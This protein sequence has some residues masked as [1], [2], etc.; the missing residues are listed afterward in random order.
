MDGWI[1]ICLLGLAKTA[2]THCLGW[3][4][5]MDGWDNYL[6]WINQLGPVF[7]FH[8]WLFS[9]CFPWKRHIHRAT[10]SQLLEALTKH[11]PSGCFFYF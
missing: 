5:W 1:S 9:F 6:M 2:K 8:F 4:I 11:V 3:M 7:L 10:Y